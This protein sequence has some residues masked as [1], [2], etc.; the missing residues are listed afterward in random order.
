MRRTNVKE[1]GRVTFTTDIKRRAARRLR[2]AAALG[3]QHDELGVAV[4]LRVDA[5][6]G[7]ASQ[8]CVARGGSSVGR[9][10]G[11]RPRRR[12][13][14]RAAD[15]AMQRSSHAA[16]GAARMSHTSPKQGAQ[17]RTLRRCAASLLAGGRRGSGSARARGATRVASQR[18]LLLRRENARARE[19]ADLQPDGPAQR[20]GDFGPGAAGVKGA[21][22]RL[23]ST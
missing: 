20:Q 23:L 14:A 3:H 12:R 21:A 15:R 18:H 4:F 8:T 5:V 6:E 2:R 17:R 11:E 19:L 1:G 13:L 16:H 7:G 9:T 22:D 10:R